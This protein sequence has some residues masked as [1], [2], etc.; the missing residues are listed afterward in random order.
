MEDKRLQKLLKE[1][2]SEGLIVFYWGAE[3]KHDSP[4]DGVDYVGIDEQHTELAKDWSEY[5][6]K[7]LWE[8]S[9][10]NNGNFISDKEKSLQNSSWNSALSIL[11][12]K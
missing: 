2:K 11:H 1:L 3:G 5:L 7:I 12:W 10:D 6:A 8:E 9:Y 4:E